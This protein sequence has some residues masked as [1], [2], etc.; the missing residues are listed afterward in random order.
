MTCAILNRV[1]YSR[2]GTLVAT[3]RILENSATFGGNAQLQRP[4]ARVGLPLCAR[5]SI[6]LVH[7]SDYPPRIDRLIV[8]RFPVR[9]NRSQASFFYHIQPGGKL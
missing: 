9:Y 1:R 6:S 5:N 3:A 7:R 4:A 2:S 8:N